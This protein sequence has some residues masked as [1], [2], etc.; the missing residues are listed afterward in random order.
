M[1]TVHIHYSNSVKWFDDFQSIYSVQTQYNGVTVFPLPYS[2][3]VF[4]T[5]VCYSKCPVFNPKCQH[6]LCDVEDDDDDDDNNDDDDN[7]DDNN[8]NNNNNNN[9]RA[10]Q[11]RN[12]EKKKTNKD[13]KAEKTK[14]C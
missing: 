7:D 5:V 6:I 14:E 13:S 1:C 12:T 9:R 4:N 8:N 2:G 10:L 11:G 3:L